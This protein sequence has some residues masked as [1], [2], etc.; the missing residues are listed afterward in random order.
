MRSD[1]MA[2]SFFMRRMERQD[3]MDRAKDGRQSAQTQ[4]FGNAETRIGDNEGF[5]A[6]YD[7]VAQ[8]NRQARTIT[9]ANTSSR[10]S[11]VQ[12][13]DQEAQKDPRNCLFLQA[14]SQVSDATPQ[15][16]IQASADPA[17]PASELPDVSQIIDLVLQQQPVSL[18]MFKAPQ[19]GDSVDN[20]TIGDL[21]AA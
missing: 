6:A 19:T 4:G 8:M 16:E 14:D 17:F 10:S 18:D 15:A 12:V 9:D 13:K 1:A 3:R 11:N 20:L 5:K 21:V 2:S 7:K